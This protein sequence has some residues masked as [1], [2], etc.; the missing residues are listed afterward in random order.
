MRP[1]WKGVLQLSSVPIP[2][3]LSPVTAAAA[4]LRFQTLHGL[5][6]TPLQPSH[7]CTHCRRDVP[8]TES[9]RGYRYARHCYLLI[10]GEEPEVVEVPARATTILLRFADRTELAEL[11]FDDRAYRII[12]DGPG[13]AEAHAA[14]RDTMRERRRVAFGTLA[15]DGQDHAVALV[16][17]EQDLLVH[18]LRPSPVTA[19]RIVPSQE[20][21]PGRSGSVT[22]RAE[23]REAV[24]RVIATEVG[25]KRDVPWSAPEDF[26]DDFAAPP[27]G[28][29]L[30]G[31]MEGGREPRP[32]AGRPWGFVGLGCLLLAVLGGVAMWHRPTTEEWA[33]RWSPSRVLARIGGER[34][35]LFRAGAPSVV[36]GPPRE[37]GVPAAIERPA[38]DAAGPPSALSASP[39]GQPTAEPVTSSAPTPTGEAARR[40]GEPPL[41]PRQPPHASREPVGVMGHDSIGAGTA[42]GRSAHASSAAASPWILWTR[43]DTRA[44]G[45][46]GSELLVG[47][48]RP[49]ERFESEAECQRRVLQSFQPAP[50]GGW[51]R[52]AG[53]EEVRAGCRPA[54]AG[55]PGA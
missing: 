42:N 18:I 49:A 30:S 46:P 26:L 1:I 2:V 33:R 39:A 7:F 3:T 20:G 19:A 25:G 10:A 34:W 40:D 48:W 9:V 43:R 38:P 36:A 6:R 52:E 4:V 14:L 21:P 32:R 11:E 31:P 35:L 53:Q 37:T 29:P 13:A 55:R 8:G 28:L 23:Y 17:R 41:T 27:A 16:P 15:L 47:P 54:A 22:S 12:P 45:S 50:E 51:V 44:A 5:C 24:H